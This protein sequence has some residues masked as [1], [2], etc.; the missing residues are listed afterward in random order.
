MR[1]SI[2]QLFVGTAV[3]IA[4][5]A[6]GVSAVGAAPGKQVSVKESQIAVARYQQ[7]PVDGDRSDEMRK[8]QAEKK[9]Q[10]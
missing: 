9:R 7:T 4:M 3:A 8:R 1:S 2:R 10:A 5:A 6:V